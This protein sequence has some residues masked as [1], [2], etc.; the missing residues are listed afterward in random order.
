MGNGMPIRVSGRANV[1]VGERLCQ[2]LQ[3]YIDH[4]LPVFAATSA[5]F[6]AMQWLF[7]AGDGKSG[8]LS[9]SQV[10]KTILD[11]VAERVGAVF[12]PHLFRALAVDFALKRDPG[13][14][15]HCRQLLGDKSLQVVLTHYAAV[16]IREAAEHQDRLVDQEADRLAMPAPPVRRRRNTGGR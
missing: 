6:A 2:M 4:F 5:D 12:H 16:R 9:A 1:S 14:L 8:P 11:T 3:I 15:E 10:R 7:P 13:G